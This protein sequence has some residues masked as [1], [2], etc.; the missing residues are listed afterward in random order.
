M[1]HRAEPQDEAAEWRITVSRI[2]NA[3]PRQIW[4]AWKDAASI[5]R[6]W[7]PDGFSSTV[8]VLDL[9]PGGRFDVVMHGPD[10]TDYANLYLVDEVTP[11]RRLRYTNQGSAEFGLA[12]FVSV[13]DIEP[14]TTDGPSSRSPRTRVTLTSEFASATDYRKHVEDFHAVEGAHQL[15]ERLEQT[16]SPS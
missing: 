13:V 4:A 14:V 16:A 15:L 8:N 5:A 9:R 11:E 7:G 1:S 6:W 12:P 10:G 2:M 3:T